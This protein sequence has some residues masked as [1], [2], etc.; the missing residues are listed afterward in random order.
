MFVGGAGNEGEAG[1]QQRC[2]SLRRRRGRQPSSDDDAEA[3]NEAE[4]PSH[5]QD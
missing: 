1:R 3:T 5:G 2:A 4:S